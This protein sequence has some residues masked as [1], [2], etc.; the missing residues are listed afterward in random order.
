[1]LFNVEQD[2]GHRIL[3]YVVP[4]GYSGTPSIRLISGGADVLTCAANDHRQALVDA[5]RHETG[6]CGFNIGPDLLPD[7][8]QML[9]LTIEDEETGLLIYR[10]PR[11][12]L[13][14]RKSSGLINI[15]FHFGASTRPSATGCNIFRKGLSILDG[16]QSHRCFS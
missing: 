16:K 12:D 15:S 6:R 5:G 13:L 9:D 2:Q 3:A 11:P 4:D 14:N 10:R 1:M 7:L 8:E